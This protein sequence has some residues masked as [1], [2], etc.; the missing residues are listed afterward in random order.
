MSMKNSPI[1]FTTP[2]L[3]IEAGVFSF[4]SHLGRPCTSNSVAIVMA[5]KLGCSFIYFKCTHLYASN[6]SQ[7]FI[8]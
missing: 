2:D 3:T 8:F 5:F 1:V 7:I 6:D 4:F